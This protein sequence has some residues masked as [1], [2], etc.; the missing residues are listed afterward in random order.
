MDEAAEPGPVHGTRGDGGQG[1][2]EPAVDFN[3][4]GVAVLAHRLEHTVL[5]VRASVHA[6]MWVPSFVQRA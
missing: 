2:P 1:G 6:N 4:G 3:G 5:A